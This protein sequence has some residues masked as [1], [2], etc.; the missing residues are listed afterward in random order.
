MFS[1]T[2]TYLVTALEEVY[3]KTKATFVVI[4]DEWDCIFREKK[5]D[6]A[7]HAKYLDFL[8]DL[9]KDQPYVKL[10][11]M[12][13]ILPIKKYGTHSALNMFNEYSM[14]DAGDVAEFIGF[15]K[16]EVNELCNKYNMDFEE[17]SY[18]YDGYSL[19]NNFHIYN[20]RSV[21]ECVSRKQFRSYWTRTETYE[22]LQIYIDMNYDGLKESIVGLLAGE[23]YLIDPEDFAND[24]TTFHTKNDVLTLLVHLG[25]LTY[26]F[27]TEEVR[28]PNEEIRR[29]FKRAMKAPKWSNVIKTIDESSRLLEATLQ[30]DSETVAK[31][32]DIVHQNRRH[33]VSQR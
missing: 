14:T 16:N 24:M 20:P 11:Y 12:T 15:T 27:D 10:A 29:E 17:V 21:V 19:E 18:W 25:Y 5:N 2:E 28:I 23:R 7:A 3:A 32:L 4:V 6:S 9:L 30:G 8:R 13:G 33:L 31:S 22:A 26:N 1:S